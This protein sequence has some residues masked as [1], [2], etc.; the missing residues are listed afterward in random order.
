MPTTLA[1][2]LLPETVPHDDAAA[3]SGRAALLVAALGA[4]PEHLLLAT[5][6][7]LH[8]DYRTQAMPESLQLMHRLRADGIAAVVDLYVTV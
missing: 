7:L 4:H 5:Q 8:Q 3:N 1:R 2:K 6:D